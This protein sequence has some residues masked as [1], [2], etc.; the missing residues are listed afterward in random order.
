M[1]RVLSQ[2]ELES[3]PSLD[4]LD[5]APRMSTESRNALEQVMQ[6]LD[7]GKTFQLQ[8]RVQCAQRLQH[9]RVVSERQRWVQPADNVQFRDAQTQRFP[10][11]LDDFLDGE[12]ESVRIALLARKGAELAAQDAVIRVIDV[13]VEN[14]ARLAAH[15]SLPRQIRDGADRVQI[16]AFEQP[17]GVGLGNPLTGGDLVIKIAQRTVLDEKPH[18]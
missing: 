7:G 11:L 17:Q 18:E 2:S 12:L 16:L 3:F 15:F 13:A 1:N 4:W 8:P 5:V 6:N 9:V 14:V 10:G